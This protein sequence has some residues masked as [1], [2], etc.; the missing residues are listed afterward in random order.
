MGPAAQARPARPCRPPTHILSTTRFLARDPRLPRQRGRGPRSLTRLGERG[1]PVRRAAAAT[2]AAPTR[3]YSRME[4][5]NDFGDLPPI[6]GIDFA[7][8][9][10][11]MGSASDHEYLDYDI[12]GRNW[13]E[14]MF[15]YC[16]SAYLAGTFGGGAMGV[17]EGLRSA[18]SSR[19][20]IVMNSVMNGAGKRGSRA[21]NALGC[22]ALMYSGLET[23]VDKA[24]TDLK[25]DLPE[26]ANSVLA[27]MATGLV[28]K[29]AAGPRAALLA[30]A[31][32]GAAVGA[33]FGA[34][35][36]AEQIFGR[37]IG[38]LFG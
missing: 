15:S 23:L 33:S 4:N 32:G 31:I 36:V 16:G 22:L 2:A 27:G 10:P 8:Q 34:E 9:R 19:M 3:Q 1:S 28:Y 20:R 6:P 38:K 35:M 37:R 25:L 11:V 13:A 26:Q 14:T 5:R 7:L 18:P 29:S 12:K 30:S 17:V 21:G 24:D